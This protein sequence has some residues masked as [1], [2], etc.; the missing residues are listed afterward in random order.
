M[1]MYVSSE[2]DRLV[3]RDAFGEVKAKTQ[4][5]VVNDVVTLKPFRDKILV[6]TTRAAYLDKIMQLCVYELKIGKK[7]VE[8]KTYSCTKSSL[9]FPV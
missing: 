2:G 4:V 6:S 9:H 3:I 7:V 5:I 1:Y 8:L